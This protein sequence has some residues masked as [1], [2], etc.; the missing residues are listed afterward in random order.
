MP[1]MVPSSPDPTLT[2]L[3]LILIR[4]VLAGLSALGIV[5]GIASDA[6]LEPL[7]AAVVGAGTVIWA[8]VEKIREK[9]RDH[10]GSVASAQRG[11]PV[12]PA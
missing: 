5:H 6:I 12:Q 9:R 2:A 4:Y 11:T 8:I 10:A 1:P 7:A 3:V